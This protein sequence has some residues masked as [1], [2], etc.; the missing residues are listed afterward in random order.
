MTYELAPTPK[1]LRIWQHNLN[2]SE[3]AQFDLINSPIHENWDIVLLQEPYIDKYGNTKAM[4]KWHT[5]YPTAHLTDSS[6]NRSVILVNTALDSNAWTQVAFK[7][8]ND[9]TVIKFWLPSGQ[10]TLFN[11]YND[12]MHSDTLKLLRLYLDLH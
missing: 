8:S 9:M 3:K 1:R 2:K 11:I 7:G 10:I 6:S 4:S 12:C 5:V